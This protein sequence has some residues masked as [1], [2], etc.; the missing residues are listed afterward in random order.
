MPTKNYL[1]IP[2]FTW[3]KIMICKLYLNK[4]VFKTFFIIKSKENLP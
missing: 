4:V 3:E 1:K 2:Y